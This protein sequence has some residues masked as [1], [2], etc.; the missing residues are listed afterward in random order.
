MV[1]RSLVLAALIAGPSVGQ[2]ADTLETVE[3]SAGSWVKLRVETARL[4]TAWQEEKT[5]VESLVTALNER[6]ATAEERRDLAKAKTVKE[7]EELDGLRAK[8]ET[9]SGDL[10]DFER[11]LQEMTA[12]LIALRPTLPP[13]LSEALEMSFRSLGNTALPPG[14]RMQLTMNVL[15]RCV[16]FNR[17]ITVGED[18]LTLDGAATPKSY[19]VIYWGLSHGYAVDRATRQAWLGSPGSPGWRWEPKPEAFDRVLKL[20]AIATDKADPDFVT[21]PATVTR[22]LPD[23]P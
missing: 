19:G 12:K 16:Q 2:A 15:N 13:R 11:R 23:K 22:T 1:A 14:E 6:A 10:R 21:V 7:R 5:L 9:E 4:E 20:I 8:I 3:K 17:S 18:V